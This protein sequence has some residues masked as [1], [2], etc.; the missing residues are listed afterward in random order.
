MTFGLKTPLNVGLASVGRHVRDVLLMQRERVV[1]ARSLD[2]PS[3]NPMGREERVQYDGYAEQ[4]A[5]DVACQLSDAARYFA[6][7]LSRLNSTIGTVPSCTTIRSHVSDHCVG[8]PSI[9][10]TGST[11]TPL[12]FVISWHSR[13]V[14][15]SGTSCSDDPGH[16]GYLAGGIP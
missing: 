10:C 6:N 9:P 13:A 15:A 5:T 2:R 14:P 4:D 11:T 1:A 12:T 16:G 8:W 7:V 3:F